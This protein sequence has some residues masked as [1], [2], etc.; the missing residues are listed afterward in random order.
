M[1]VSEDTKASISDFL[2]VPEVKEYEKYLGLSAVVRRKRKASLNYIK[3]R[4]W[5]KLQGWKEKLLSQ[6]GREI[7]LKA[8][9]QAIP[10][11]A[12]SCFKLPVGLCLEIEA[13]IRKFFW[14]QRGDNRKIHWVKWSELCKPK[15]QGGM[16]FKD[17]ATFN[18]ALLAKQTWRLL[19][20][21]QSLFYKIFKAKF[22]P[23]TS[24][25]EARSPSNASYAWKSIMKGREVIKRG[26]VWRIGTGTSIRVWGDNWLPVKNKPRILSP[27][28]EGTGTIWVSD[29]IDPI[30]RT[31]KE[32]MLDRFFYDFEAATI[33]NIPLCR[34]IQEDVLI[35]PFNSDGE[36]SV[37]LGYRFLQE[38]NTLQQPGPSNAEAMKPLW[39]KIWSMDVPNKVKNLVWRACTNSLPTKVNL[40]RRKV[41][42][43][44]LCAIC[45]VHQEDVVHALYCCPALSSLWSQTPIWNHEALKGS[46][47]FTDVM[48]FV[49]AGNKEP[50]LFSLVIWNLWNRRNNL[51]LGKTALPLDKITEHARARQLEALA[52]S[53]IPALHRSSH[54]L[55]WSPPEA[56]RY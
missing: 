35:W 45:G 10:T 23:N 44:G 6:V 26:T 36:Y 27:K 43:D 53:A 37:K 2:Q 30:N 17:L 51:R 22:F 7:L 13:L 46:K 25:M 21:T 47:N 16:G 32:D 54:Q 55:A 29:L 31:W 52:P 15:S 50:E 9:V 3:E 24:V 39:N 40:V 11:F 33:K 4:V 41:T 56:Q 20:D 12:M 42:S 18:D 28:L 38:A 1:T 19:H 49:L 34:S 14:G 5:S 48:G 8:V